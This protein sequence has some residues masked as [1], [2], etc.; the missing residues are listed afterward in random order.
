MASV[1]DAYNH[2]WNNA[3][4]LYKAPRNPQG[5]EVG[6]FYYLTEMCL[7]YLIIIMTVERRKWMLGVIP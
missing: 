4:N 7:C 6:G 1:A 5:K 3:N 2:M